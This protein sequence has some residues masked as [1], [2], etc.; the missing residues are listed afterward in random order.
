MSK[1]CINTWRRRPVPERKHRGIWMRF[2]IMLQVSAMKLDDIISFGSRTHDGNNDIILFMQ[3]FNLEIQSNL[4]TI[5]SLPYVK[6]GLIRSQRR[7]GGDRK[8]TI[9]S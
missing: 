5:Y 4:S 1:L 7:L 8:W 6:I 2:S 9:L 3:L